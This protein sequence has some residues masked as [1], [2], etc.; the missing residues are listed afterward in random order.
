LD[1]DLGKHLRAGWALRPASA[2]AAMTS[3]NVTPANFLDFQGGNLEVGVSSKVPRQTCG[4]V[5]AFRTCTVQ[6]R[7]EIHIFTNLKLWARSAAD[8]FE[9]HKLLPFGVPHGTSPGQ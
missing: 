1:L 8:F 9:G 6:E 2:T 5:P 7:F 4:A 3:G